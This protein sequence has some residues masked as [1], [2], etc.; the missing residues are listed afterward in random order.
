MSAETA[1]AAAALRKGRVQ[2]DKEGSYERNRPVCF[3]QEWKEF[4]EAVKELTGLESVTHDDYQEALRRFL[5]VISNIYSIEDGFKT[6]LFDALRKSLGEF[7]EDIET[8]DLVSDTGVSLTGSG[9]DAVYE[10]LKNQS[11]L[12]IKLRGC[13]VGF[14]TEVSRVE[15]LKLPIDYG[16]CDGS[17]PDLACL[18]FGDD[19]HNVTAEY[20]GRQPQLKSRHAPLA[21]A[22]LHAMDV[23]HCLARRGHNRAPHPIFVAAVVL[24]ARGKEGGW[25]DRVCCMESSLQIPETFG[26]GVQV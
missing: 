16:M 13:C 15:S 24:A 4:I 8:K 1:T 7:C 11:R 17:L 2:F 20:Q 18:V 19:A 12:P 3:E 6:C 21:K 5:P 23:W 26:R 14:A 9:D 22:L 10:T 25:E